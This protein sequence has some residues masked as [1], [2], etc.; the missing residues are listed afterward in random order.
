[1]GRGKADG[2]RPVGRAARGWKRHCHGFAPQLTCNARVYNHLCGF[3]GLDASELDKDAFHRVPDFGRD[4]WD[5]VERVLTSL[6]DRF[7]KG[8][9]WRREPPGCRPGPRRG[10]SSHP[11]CDKSVLR[12]AAVLVPLTLCRAALQQSKM[13]ASPE[14]SPG[15]LPREAYGVRPACWR[16]RTVPCARKREPAPRTPTASR[17]S[18]ALQQSKWFA[19]REGFPGDLLR[20][21]YPCPFGS[22]CG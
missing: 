15:D 6:E 22:I 14:S 4:E 20:A 17:S 13:L 9:L 5:A 2:T 18:A 3:G 1:M 8:S 19:S 7:R 21:A 10:S 16:S 12:H 11:P